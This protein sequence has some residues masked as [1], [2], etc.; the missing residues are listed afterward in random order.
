MAKEILLDVHELQPPAPMEL[1]MDALQK[2]QAGEYVKM[3]HRM[4]PFP[5]YNILYDNGFKFKAVP[6]TVSA[7]DIYIWKANDKDSSMA[8]EEIISTL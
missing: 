1:A 8:I 4:Q 3:I 5:L 6:G 7:F 2:L